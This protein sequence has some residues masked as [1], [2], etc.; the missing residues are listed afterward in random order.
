MPTSTQTQSTLRDRIAPSLENAVRLAMLA[1]AVALMAAAAH[2]SVT[3]IAA[4]AAAPTFTS[5]L[6]MSIGFCALALALYRRK[7]TVEA[8]TADAKAD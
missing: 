7:R 6:Q 5:A 8:Q 4:P 2:A 1:V 3:D